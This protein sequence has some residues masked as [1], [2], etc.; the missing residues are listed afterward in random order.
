MSGSLRTNVDPNHEMK[1]KDI[2]AAL[3][4]SSL[5]YTVT[6]WPQGLDTEIGETGINLR[7]VLCLFLSQS[8]CR[9]IY[10]D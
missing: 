10:N 7:S 2:W 5:L 9:P 4:M 6:S 3:N 1:E 8:Y